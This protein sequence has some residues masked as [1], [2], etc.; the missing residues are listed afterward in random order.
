MTTNE[1]RSLVPFRSDADTTKPVEGYL[2]PLRIILMSEV[3]GK[4]EFWWVRYDAGAYPQNPEL[5][6]L[7][8]DWDRTWEEA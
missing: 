5:F 1:P 6:V 8:S 4:P 7:R 3:E 2:N